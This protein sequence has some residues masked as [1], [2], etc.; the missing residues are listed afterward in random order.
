[1]ERTLT[2]ERKGRSRECSPCAGSL[3]CFALEFPKRPEQRRPRAGGGWMKRSEGG[4][5]L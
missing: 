3:Q 1:M 5:K 4:I 2:L